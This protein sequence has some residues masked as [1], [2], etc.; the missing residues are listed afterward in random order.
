MPQQEDA[1]EKSTSSTSTLEGLNLQLLIR[2]NYAIEPQLTG[3]VNPMPINFEQEGEV[4]AMI[5]RALGEVPPAERKKF[6]GE[7]VLPLL[8]T[9][10]GEALG[11]ARPQFEAGGSEGKLLARQNFIGQS[12]QN[13]LIAIT[14][15][16]EDAMDNARSSLDAAARSLLL[17]QSSLKV[18]IEQY[19]TLLEAS[20]VRFQDAEG[21]GGQ[22]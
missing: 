15:A 4:V 22:A 13:L 8:D 19:R 3:A 1:P 16:M 17:S 5:V 14:C 7:H 12:K 11:E 10:L 9:A 6:L 2:F 18:F 20:G 21:L